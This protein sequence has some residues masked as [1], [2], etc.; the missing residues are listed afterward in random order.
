V[1]W[2]SSK[3]KAIPYITKPCKQVVVA[4]LVVFTFNIFP[5]FSGPFL[6]NSMNISFHFNP[7][8]VVQICLTLPFHRDLR[9]GE[10]AGL[11][12]HL[13]ESAPQS[14]I[15]IDSR[16]GVIKAP[17]LLREVWPGDALATA[18]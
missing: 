17:D 15:A 10:Q 9:H 12:N 5:R 7:L 2:P 1:C 3:T 14:G 6:P 18:A 4:L 13:Q 8:S 11:E 16:G